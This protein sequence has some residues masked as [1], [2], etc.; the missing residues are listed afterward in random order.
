[1]KKGLVLLLAISVFAISSTVSAQFSA[2]TVPSQDN[3][4][5]EA[6]GPDGPP[7]P[8]PND[9]DQPAPPAKHHHGHHEP[10]PPPPDPDN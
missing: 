1:M 6:D 3:L 9:P 5:F 7:P 8:P 4:M 10:P 2:V